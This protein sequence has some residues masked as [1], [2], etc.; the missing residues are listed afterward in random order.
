MAELELNA[1]LLED[2]LEILC[3]IR[4]HAGRDP[5]EEFNHENFRPQPPPHRT[6]LKAYNA[7]AD[8]DQFLRHIGKLQGTG[9][10]NH[11]LLIDFNA[12]QMR[13]VGACG[14]DDIL[15]LNGLRLALFRCH[16]NFAGSNDL[17]RAVVSVDLVL[18]EQIFDTGRVAVDAFL[19]EDL[20]GFEVELRRHLDAHPL[21]TVT[22]FLKKFGCMQQ[23]L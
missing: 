12:G 10:R 21:E 1:L 18:L 9:R 2:A 19:L 4:I 20:H 13:H 7:G 22:G 15:G 3:D 8:N 16:F 11:P 5:V 6:K 17:S 23:G 14:Y